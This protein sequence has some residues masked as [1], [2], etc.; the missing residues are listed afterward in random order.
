MWIDHLSTSCF[1]SVFSPGFCCSKAIFEI[2]MCIFDVSYRPRYAAFV[3]KNHWKCIKVGV[4]PIVRQIAI[5]SGTYR[6]PLKLRSE[7]TAVKSIVNSLVLFSLSSRWCG[8]HLDQHMLL[9]CFQTWH[10]WIRYTLI[11]WVVSLCHQ[12][13]PQNAHIIA[14]YPSLSIY[15][16]LIDQNSCVPYIPAVHRIP[17][18]L[19]RVRHKLVIT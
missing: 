16:V 7:N 17:G 10:I 4:V 19:S 15:S 11:V 2:F 8:L 13:S 3:V 14:A 1:F 12:I 6:I 18:P 9:D 5:I